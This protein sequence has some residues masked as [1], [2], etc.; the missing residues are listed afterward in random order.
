M[1]STPWRQLALGSLLGEA[2]LFLAGGARAAGS[3]L[4]QTSPLVW[5]MIIISVAGAVVVYGFLA[6]ALWKFRD[7]HTK[8]RRYG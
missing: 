3:N 7:P 5:V 6:Y 1:R 4:D 8:G 2:L